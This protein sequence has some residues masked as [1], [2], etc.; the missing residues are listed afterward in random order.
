L[1]DSAARATSFSAIS[2]ISLRSASTPR[3]LSHPP[4]ARHGRESCVQPTAAASRV[5]AASAAARA[6][7]P[8]GAPL[9]APAVGPSP[10]TTISDAT[11]R[12]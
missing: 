1:P 4:S 6:P 3:A 5:R 12:S 7:P 11:M 10:R 2:M 9:S 8:L